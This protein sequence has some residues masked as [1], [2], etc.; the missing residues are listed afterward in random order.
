[1]THD[2]VSRHGVT[3]DIYSLTDKT[4]TADTFAVVENVDCRIFKTKVFTFLATT[5][6]LDVKILGGFD[7]TNFPYEV[8]ASFAVA[9]DANV[10]KA[11]TAIYPYLQVQTK[12]TV[13]GNNGTLATIFFGTSI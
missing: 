8:E 7:N 12:P 9:K 3:S 5:K 13:A 1:M 2:L 10:Y 11:V 4:T 6:G